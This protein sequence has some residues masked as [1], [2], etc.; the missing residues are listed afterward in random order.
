MFPG[1]SIRLKVSDAPDPRTFLPA[2]RPNLS[3]NSFQLLAISFQP[4]RGPA[5]NPGV[6]QEKL[7]AE[8]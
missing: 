6:P 4:F 5:S 8:S 3:K 1:R 2:A 7:K